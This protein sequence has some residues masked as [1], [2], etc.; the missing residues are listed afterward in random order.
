MRRL[1]PRPTAPAPKLLL[2]L[3]ATLL[4]GP[5]GACGGKPPAARPPDL[6][7]FASGGIFGQ[8]APCG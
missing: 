2:A 7:V 6:V 3:A 4:L 1:M 5:L 8:L